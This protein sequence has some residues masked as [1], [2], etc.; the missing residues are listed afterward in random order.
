MRIIVVLVS[1]L[2]CLSLTGYAAE[3]Q[4]SLQK[5]T[6]SYSSSGIPTVDWL[7]AKFGHKVSR[8]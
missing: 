6:L 7:I 1:T 2:I 5:I 4:T 3:A 8:S